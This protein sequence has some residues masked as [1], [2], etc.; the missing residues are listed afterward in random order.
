MI[1][2]ILLP[3]LFNSVDILANAFL[4]QSEE[5]Y[6]AGINY[7]DNTARHTEKNF[8]GKLYE[9]IKWGPYAAITFY[10]FYNYI[11]SPKQFTLT[12]KTLLLFGTIMYATSIILTN[13]TSDTFLGKMMVQST[14]PMTLF[15]TLYFKDRRHTAVCKLFVTAITVSYLFQL[16]LNGF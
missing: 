6:N 5:L 3:I 13:K 1:Y 10:A 9:Y 4:S 7:M 8:Y 16:M 11:K 2:I 15:L 12:E 14:F